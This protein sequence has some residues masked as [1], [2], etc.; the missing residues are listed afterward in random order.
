MSIKSL[1]IVCTGP[2]FVS[3][4]VVPGKLMC[5]VVCRRLSSF[6]VVCRR[7]SSPLLSS[8][9]LLRIFVLPALPSVI[10]FFDVACLPPLNVADYGCSQIL[11]ENCGRYVH[12]VVRVVGCS[13][14]TVIVRFFCGSCF[15][16]PFFVHP[17]IHQFPFIIHHCNRS[18]LLWELFYWSLFRSSHHSTV[19]PVYFSPPV[20][21]NFV[22]SFFSKWVCWF[23]DVVPFRFVWFPF[24]EIL[25][26][27]IFFRHHLSFCYH[28]VSLNPSICLLEP[29]CLL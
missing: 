13:F 16:G 4:F 23:F 2:E 5:L 6:V 27:R 25:M 14:L 15:T 29:V 11:F 21:P 19:H 22:F 17:I 10:P 1:C 26:D 12:W 9:D 24:G 8:S 3:L 7:L 18:F 20:F 28:L